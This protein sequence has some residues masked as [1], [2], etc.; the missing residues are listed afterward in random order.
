MD[1]RI[2][3]AR[4]TLLL[5]VWGRWEASPNSIDKPRHTTSLT[6]IDMPMM[7][8][9]TGSNSQGA[10]TQQIGMA[11]PLA[12]LVGDYFFDGG[13][14]ELMVPNTPVVPHRPPTPHGSTS[15]GISGGQDSNVDDFDDSS[16][17]IIHKNGDKF[18]DHSIHSAI[19]NLF[20][21]SMDDVW[22]TY[23]SI[24]EKTRR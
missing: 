14:A 20:W 6:P 4:T 17:P 11:N 19:M 5:A 16:L 2:K 21:Q 18:D 7:R 24:T 12:D 22:P 1:G 3:A 15:R 9:V 10:I 23:K 13:D 8:G